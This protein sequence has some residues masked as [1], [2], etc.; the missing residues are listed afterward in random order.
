[1]GLLNDIPGAKALGDDDLV[2]AWA[3]SIGR[4][5]ATMVGGFADMAAALMNAAEKARGRGEVTTKPVGGS[6]W[7]AEK[8]GMPQE[9]GSPYADLALS[10]GVPGLLPAAGKGLWN[11]EEAVRREAQAYRAPVGRRGQAGAIE[12][13][14]HGSPAKF[15]R[16]ANEKIGTGEGAQA[17][18]YGHYGAE[19]PG[20]AISYKEGLS[21]K[22]DVYSLNGKEV[23][24]NLLKPQQKMMLEAITKPHIYGTKQSILDNLQKTGASEKH[25]REVSDAWDTLA[26]QKPTV[27]T[28]DEGNLYKFRLEWPAEQ[29]AAGKR[30]LSPE[31]MLDWDK[32]LSQQSKQVQE[33]FRRAQ[34]AD[35]PAPK[36]HPSWEGQG[37]PI[38]YFAG[39]PTGSKLYERLAGYSDKDSLAF[40]DR[41]GQS[42]ASERLQQMGIPGIRYLDAGSRNRN[43]WIAK[44]PRGGENVFY[45]EE[46]AKAFVARN[47]EYSLIA[48]KRTANVV[49]FDP[50]MAQIL[51]RNGVPLKGLLDAGQ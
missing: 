6:Q 23:D 17:Y 46:A 36:V 26:K 22:K 4:L 20:V 38:D 8:L 42:I 29:L 14:Y 40:S 12:P 27:R 13:L 1:M 16:F 10:A 3:R 32:P 21:G 47:P 15:E 33:A 9:P 49:F 44:S 48:P 24:A 2:A 5:P 18:G 50:D 37:K 43:E 35:T 51:E 7:L 31:D 30:P 19:R 11:A 41:A 39:D 25:I 45:N 28:V 34:S